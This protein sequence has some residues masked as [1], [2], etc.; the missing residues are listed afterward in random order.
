MMSAYQLAD[1]PVQTE[2]EINNRILLSAPARARLRHS[3]AHFDVLKAEITDVLDASDI[4]FR[5]WVNDGH[6]VLTVDDQSD[7]PVQWWALLI[8]DAVVNLRAALDHM[9][10]SLSVAHRG[11]PPTPLNARWRGIQFPIC[12]TE[13]M[14]SQAVGGQRSRL[15][16]LPPELI[17]VVKKLQPLATSRP[18]AHALWIF[19]GTG[20]PE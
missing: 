11:S 3:E 6:F 4:R 19:E 1:G 8:G 18:R 17:A 7:L 15:W 13:E 10:W 20:Q 2:T 16:A 14:W 9:A 5:P 12:L